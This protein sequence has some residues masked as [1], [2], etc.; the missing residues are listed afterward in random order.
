[1]D[2]GS[3]DG[4]REILD[5]FA[6]RDPRVKVIRHDRNRGAAA[7]RNLGLD[8]ANGEFVQFTDA[9][10]LLDPDALRLLT[11][12]ARADTVPIVRGGIVG[13]RSATPEKQ[14]DLDL[15]EARSRVRPL[16]DESTWS[17]WWHTTYL[18]SRRLLVSEGIRYPDLCS[19]EDPVF[20]AHVLVARADRID[21]SD[22]RLSSSTHAAR[23][24]RSD[25]LPT[26]ARLPTAR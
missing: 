2:D 15:P 25:D 11:S 26:S 17:P 7:A 1:M 10:D 16:E 3:T 22:G 8:A 23:R 5:R 18:F 12:A 24:E 20:L 9:D 4:S 19:G 6:E 21:A 14:L 13:F